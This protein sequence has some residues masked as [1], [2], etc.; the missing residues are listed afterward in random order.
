[1]L[2]LRLVLQQLRVSIGL[3]DGVLE[4]GAAVLFDQLARVNEVV[5]GLFQRAGQLAVDIGELRKVH[6][7]VNT[8]CRF[9]YGDQLLKTFPQIL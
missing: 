7:L 3:T 6:L 9:E 1:M 4:V 5:C 2:K 8:R